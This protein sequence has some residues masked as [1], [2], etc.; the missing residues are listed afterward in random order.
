MSSLSSERLVVAAQEAR[1]LYSALL[2][3]EARMPWW[4]AV[5]LT[6]SSGRQAQSYTRE[7]ESRRNQGL[8]P[9]DVPFLV[10]PDP[11]NRRVGS[12]GA[13]LHALHI[14]LASLAPDL[15]RQD[16]EATEQWWSKQ[17]VLM[18]HSGGDSR[19][20]PQ[21]S[22][23]GKLFS[24]LPVKAPW[25][26]ASTLFDET[27]SIG[28][29]WAGRMPSGLVVSAGDVLLIFNQEDVAWDRPG[30]SGVAMPQSPDVATQHGVY[31]IGS[32]GR[33]YSFLQ[34]PALGEIQQAGGILPDGRVAVDSGLLRFDPRTLAKLCQVGLQDTEVCHLDLYSHFTLCL[35]GQWSPSPHDPALHRSLALALDG[36]PFNCSVADGEFTHIGTT[37]LFRSL[38]TEETD[39]LRLF[40]A[41]QRLGSIQSPGIRSA[42]IIIDSALCEGD[43]GA[44]AAVLECCLDHPLRAARGSVA[45]GLARLPETVEI[46]EDTV[47][48]QVPVRSPQGGVA[49]TVIRVYG[50]IDDAKHPTGSA[51]ATWFGRPLAA[52]IVGLSLE[53]EEVWPETPP[54][55]RCLWNA[56]LFPVTSPGEAWAAARWMLGLESDFT[57]ARWREL[58]RTSLE[59]SAAWA[60]ENALVEERTRRAISQWRAAAVQLALDGA[61]IRPML[62]YAPGL[63]ALVAAGRALEDS[64]NRAQASASNGESAA[65]SLLYQAALFYSRG[66]L[67]TEAE[68]ARAGA[69]SQI[70]SAV[71]AATAAS[72]FP[73]SSHWAIRSVHVSAPARIDFG[74]GWSDT[75]PFCLDW[76][77]TV[78]NA[79]ISLNGEYPIGTRMRVLREPVIRCLSPEGSE[80]VEYADSGSLFEPPRPGDPYSIPRAALQVCGLFAPA[81]SLRERLEAI[82]GGLEISTGVRLPMGSGLGTSSMLAATVL[83]ALAE[84][85]GHRLSAQPLSDLVLQLEQFMSTGGGWQDQAGGIFPGVKLLSTGPGAL[86]RIRYQP[87]AWSLERESEFQR[88]TVLVYTGVA[89]VARNLLQQVVGRYLAR[90]TAAVQVLHS[91]KTLALEMAHAMQDGDWDHLGQLLDRH[92]QLNQILDPNTTNA[93]VQDLLDRVRPMIRGGKL[94]GAGG[95]GFLILL[96]KSLADAMELR[97]SFD[98]YDWQTAHDGLRVKRSA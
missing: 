21:Y 85:L 48:H 16:A 63:E 62:A 84:M 37:R 95:G 43:I 53:A 64:A 91:I 13:T 72:V 92:W 29:G 57:A 31:V 7:I 40:T 68:R 73:A 70:A 26:A 18:I 10:V 55:E 44:G 2:A 78:L 3:G 9:R 47:V 87:L 59:T 79:A 66:G 75:P 81:A 61:D 39:F 89:R 93:P 71:R 54:P 96:A 36:T 97:R 8:L 94:A 6:A 86:Q 30:I 51:R 41:Q 69:F 11:R 65:A 14:L 90:E 74:G 12:G 80:A 58:P 32:G 76:G 19:R 34:K 20:L 98:S 82:G 27:M 38:L 23:S 17:R 49:G 60:D 77:G 15:D 56:A 1:Q 88:L 22:L 24:A 42:G 50:V 25:G 67:E 83:Q 52:E 5:V 45:H 33:V 28:T 35:T 4:T 46:P